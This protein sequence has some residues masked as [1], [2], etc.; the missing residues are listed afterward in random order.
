MDNSV[1]HLPKESIK[2]KN[3]IQ[4]TTDRR[5]FAT[6]FPLGVDHSANDDVIAVDKRELGKNSEERQQTE[7]VT[8]IEDGSWSTNKGNFRIA[9]A[10]G[11]TNY[12]NTAEESK[13]NSNSSVPKAKEKQETD[14]VTYQDKGNNINTTTTI[15]FDIKYTSTKPREDSGAA[16]TTT[17]TNKLYNKTA[18]ILNSSLVTSPSSPY[19]PTPNMTVNAETH[20]QHES[21]PASPNS[22]NTPYSYSE[23]PETDSKHI[24]EIAEDGMTTSRLAEVDP[25]VQGLPTQD[26]RSSSRSTSA[27]IPTPKQIIRIDRDYS[28][29]ELCQFY[30]AFPLE[31]DGRVT[32]RVF[33]QTITTLNELLERAHSPKYN[34]VDNFLACLTLYTSTLCKR[35]HY[36][37]V[38]HQTYFF[39]VGL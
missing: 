10:K 21:Q 18:N 1:G 33:Q 12:S 15:S 30:T 27:Q 13:G 39:Q 31:I 37:R 14:N 32:P 4:I 3:E 6:I 7:T 2:P 11:D 38:N 9:V 22:T 20:N 28:R 34:W 17:D 8:I 16:I 5:K 24:S 26:T 36:D 25:S 29:G 19:K 23:D 35:P